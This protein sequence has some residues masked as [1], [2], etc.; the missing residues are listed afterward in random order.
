M[1]CVELTVRYCKNPGKFS[2]YSDVESDIN[3]A[4]YKIQLQMSRK[5]H[6]ECLPSQESKRIV[7]KKILVWETCVT[8]V[9][10]VC[11]FRVRTSGSSPFKD[12]F[13]RPYVATWYTFQ[14]LTQSWGGTL[15][16]KYDIY[17][18]YIISQFPQM[19]DTEF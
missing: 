14:R 7:N 17:T 8:E 18:P 1:Y 4:L 16:V 6:T 3:F 15:S 10:E 11:Q 12:H 19:G 9:N 5:M 2:I 13:L